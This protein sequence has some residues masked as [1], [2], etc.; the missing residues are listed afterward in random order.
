MLCDDIAANL[1]QSLV[2]EHTFRS[3]HYRTEE[4]IG[5]VFAHVDMTNARACRSEGWVVSWRKG[6]NTAGERKEN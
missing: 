3:P 1:V 6:C 4:S 5:S 2:T